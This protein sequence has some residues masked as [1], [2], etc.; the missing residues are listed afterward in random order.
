MLKL[1]L[2]LFAALFV[3]HAAVLLAFPL[4]LAMTVLYIAVSALQK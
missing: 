1:S 4:F 3:M 2:L